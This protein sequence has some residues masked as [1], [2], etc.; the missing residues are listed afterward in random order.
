MPKSMTP[1]IENLFK[2]FTEQRDQLKLMIN[3]LE[4]VKVKVNSIFPDQLTARNRFYFDEKI[5]TASALFSSL[6]EIRKEI[7]KSIK[8]EIELRRRFEMEERELEET[9]DDIRKLAGKI[10]QLSGVKFTVIEAF[11]EKQEKLEDQ[12]E[13]VPKA[14]P[15][16]DGYVR[17]DELNPKEEETKNG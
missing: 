14:T 10:E 8:D 1:Q 17:L 12:L 13:L 6:L 9:D 3:D 16:S 7:I 4:Q 5:K 11:K 2:D 15:E